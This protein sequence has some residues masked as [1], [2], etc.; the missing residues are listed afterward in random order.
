MYMEGGLELARAAK[1]ALHEHQNRKNKL[2]QKQWA[3]PLSCDV[4]HGYTHGGHAHD[5]LM[6]HVREQHKTKLQVIWTKVDIS[7]LMWAQ[8]PVRWECPRR[9]QT[10]RGYAHDMDISMMGWIGFMYGTFTV[11]DIRWPLSVKM[12]SMYGTFRMQYGVY[13]RPPGLEEEGLGP[14]RAAKRAL[15]RPQNRKNE[16]GQK[17][18]ACPPGHDVTHGYTHGGHAHDSPTRRTLDTQ[19]EETRQEDEGMRE[20]RGIT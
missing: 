10:N 5:R 19:M 11:Y 12:G 13:D 16:L 14:A 17:E 8:P 20:K 15:R 3:C 1:W 2:G 4:T 7:T 6:T 9:D 18:W